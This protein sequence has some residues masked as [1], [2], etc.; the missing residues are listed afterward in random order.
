MRDIMWL[1][2]ERDDP[3]LAMHDMMLYFSEMELEVAELSINGRTDDA[4]ARE[5]KISPERLEE[6]R[7]N[8]KIRMKEMLG[9]S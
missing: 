6:I 4:I 8:M 7:N 3:H 1:K 5:L 2:Y 9:R